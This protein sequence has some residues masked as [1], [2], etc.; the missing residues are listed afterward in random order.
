ML[1]LHTQTSSV[2]VGHVSG[3][4]AAGGN[5][6]PKT[7]GMAPLV[8]HRLQAPLMMTTMI[9]PAVEEVAAAAIKTAR[10]AVRTGK[11]AAAAAAAGVEVQVHL[12][13]VIHLVTTLVLSVRVHRVLVLVR[14]PDARCCSAS[15]ARGQNCCDADSWIKLH[16]VRCRTC[17]VKFL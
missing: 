4:T 15:K 1:M 11:A 8:A 17:I 10:V 13:E 5:A 14:P 7:K 12:L 2:P 6:N 9:P 3:M 16:I